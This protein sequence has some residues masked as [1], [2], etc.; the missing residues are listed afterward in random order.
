MLRGVRARAPSA[1]LLTGLE[2]YGYVRVGEH[3]KTP[4]RAV[5]VVY[6]ESHY[7]LLVAAPGASAAAALLPRGGADGEADDVAEAPP[8]PPEGV[9][10]YYWDGLEDQREPIRLTVRP[11]VCLLYTSPSPRDGLLSRMP[12]SA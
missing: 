11:N 6:S 9:D 7:S 10:V 5:W 12:S 2:A 1:G 8:P 4:G 3:L